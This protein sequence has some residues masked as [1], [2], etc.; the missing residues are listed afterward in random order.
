MDIVLLC[1]GQG[2]QKPGM[3]KDLAER[4]P[5]ARVV[6]E[7]A[8]HALGFPLSTLCFEGP[9]PELTSTRN[10]QPALLAHGAA[11]WAAVCHQVASHVR[12][13]AGHS[14]GE[15]TA[16]CLAGTFSLPD[17]LRLVRRRGEL[18][19][20]SGLNRPGAMAAILGLTHAA[21]DAACLRALEEV[22][23]VVPA[24]YNAPD[25]VV[26]SGELPAVERAVELA[27]EAGAKR[28]IFLNVSGAF[29]SPL[30]EDAEMGLRQALTNVPV[31]PSAFPVYSNVSAHAAKDERDAKH[32]L[33]RQL[34]SPVRWSALVEHLAQDHPGARYVEIGPG[35]VLSNLV[36][37]IVPGATTSPCGTAADV[38]KLL[39]ELA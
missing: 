2:S 22:G 11:A 1:P 7:E 24:N 25:Q 4:F 27:K 15:Y 31:C 5:A 17:A 9:E 28:A 37:R 13:A 33:L 18:M 34:T 38:D 12:A 21:V 39:E 20:E 6:F 3:G 36:K 8:D 16:H 14:L 10:A 29:H 23:E 19:Y 35:S 26:I 32:L 30:M